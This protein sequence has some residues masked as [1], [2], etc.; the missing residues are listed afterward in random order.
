AIE[1]RDAPWRQVI[2]FLVEITGL[3][4]ISQVVPTGSV[5]IESPRIKGEVKKLTVAEVLDLVNEA[6][7][8]KKYLIVRR[9]ASLLVGPAD[10]PLDPIL[11]RP[12]TLDQLDECAKTEMVK[13]T[14]PLQ[15]LNAESFAPS[16][17]KLMGPF[18]Q[19]VPVEEA[20]RLILIDQAGNL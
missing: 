1:F 12:V 9:Q 8:P 5:T 3:P 14:Y 4:L 11:I 17:K 19:V 13:I 10:E 18:S 2:D 6:L 20:N 7:L 16:V 15:V